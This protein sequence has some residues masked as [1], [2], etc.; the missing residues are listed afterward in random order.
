[1]DATHTLDSPAAQESD[2]PMSVDLIQNLLA[3]NAT[4]VAELR[5]LLGVCESGVYRYTHQTELRHRQYINLFRNARD[6]RVREEMLGEL[7]P[8]SG[9]HVTWLPE[10]LDLDGDGDVDTDDAVRGGIDV[11]DAAGEALRVFLENRDDPQCLRD[12]RA[13]VGEAADR[14]IATLAILDWLEAHRPRRK[15]A[16]ARG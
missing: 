10:E 1:M 6:P 12:A 13:R 9:V 7:L 16:V 5:V 4:N 8:G 2:A 11:I 15:K 14:A 3:T